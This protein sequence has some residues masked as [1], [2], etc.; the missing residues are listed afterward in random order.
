[1]SC[2]NNGVCGSWSCTAQLHSV[3]CWL[4][5]RPIH[6]SCHFNNLSITG[7]RW[8]RFKKRQRQSQSV[9][10]KNMPS[11]E[12][13]LFCFKNIAWEDK[14]T[15]STKN[16]CLTHDNWLLIPWVNFP[17]S[18]FFLFLPFATCSLKDLIWCTVT[19]L[20]FL[21]FTIKLR[22]KQEDI[23]L[24]NGFK[25]SSCSPALIYAKSGISFVMKSLKVVTFSAVAFLAKHHESQCWVPVNRSH[26]ME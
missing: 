4:L 14:T 23:G 12:G 17:G 5:D 11:L 19:S 22:T 9:Y 20:I 18:Y 2:G 16:S 15:L 1:M 6:Q 24:N 8:W 13:D 26:L 21:Q 25:L 7:C 10:W 3:S